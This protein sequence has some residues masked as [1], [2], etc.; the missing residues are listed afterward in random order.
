MALPPLVSVSDFSVWLRE[1]ITGDQTAQAE[2]VLNSVSGLVR[3]EAKKTWVNDSNAL[4]DVPPEVTTIVFEAARR[5]WTN[6]NGY[7]SES[8]GD[9]AYRLSPDDVAVYLT[10]AECR[11]LRRFRASGGLFTISTTRGV[12]EETIYAPVSNG[13]DPIPLLRSPELW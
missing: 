2:A 6:P 7:S 4:I 3:S 13:G 12:E 9:Y 11:I 10:E 1:P 5:K 8:D